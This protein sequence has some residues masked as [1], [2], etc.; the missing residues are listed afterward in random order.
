MKLLRTQAQALATSIFR[1]FH[2]QDEPAADEIYVPVEAIRPEPD[3]EEGFYIATVRFVTNYCV[4]KVHSIKIRFKLNQHGTFD[5]KSFQYS[6][7]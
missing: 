3:G 7:G 4:R 2:A 1:Y 6:N 5:S